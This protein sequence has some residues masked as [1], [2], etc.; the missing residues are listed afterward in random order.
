LQGASD[1]DA[2]G[3]LQEMGFAEDQA[4]LALQV[5]GYDAEVAANL[6]GEGNGQVPEQYVRRSAQRQVTLTEADMHKLLVAFCAKPG[7]VQ[8]L[9]SGQPINFMAGQCRAVLSRAQIDNWLRFAYGMDFPTFIRT[10]GFQAHAPLS[11]IDDRNQ[12]GIDSHWR[13]LFRQLQPLDQVNIERI[14]DQTGFDLST[15]TQLYALADMSLEEA[16]V[17]V[18]R[19]PAY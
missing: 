10:G 6:L 5:A 12:A 1:P 19:L 7:G 2:V 18:H 11:A 14:G 13:A 8:S 9:L 17:L 15:C 16:M 3:R 4:R